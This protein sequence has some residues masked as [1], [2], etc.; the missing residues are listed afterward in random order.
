M[1]QSNRV[2]QIAEM[3]NAVD[4]SYKCSYPSTCWRLDTNQTTAVLMIYSCT[5]QPTDPCNKIVQRHTYTHTPSQLVTC[6]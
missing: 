5:L 6:F 2:F 3:S 4:I 1:T